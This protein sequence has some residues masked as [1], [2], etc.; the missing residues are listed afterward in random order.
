MH[1]I[2]YARLHVN[3]GDID[4]HGVFFG[5]LADNAEQAEMLAKQCVN[6]TKAHMI[7]PKVMDFNDGDNLIDV[8]YDAAEKFDKMFNYMKEAADTI[9][10]SKGKKS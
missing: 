7:I 5:G 1:A 10:L 8:L 4:L 6:S 2:V 9:S 3:K